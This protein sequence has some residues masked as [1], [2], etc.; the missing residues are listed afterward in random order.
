MHVHELIILFVLNINSSITVKKSALCIDKEDYL[1]KGSI[2]LNVGK[3]HNKNMSH[4]QYKVCNMI[5]IVHNICIL[6][7]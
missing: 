2:T 5:H 6:I 1:S 4:K 3:N 7:L